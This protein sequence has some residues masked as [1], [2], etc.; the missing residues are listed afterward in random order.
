MSRQLALTL[1][2]ALTSTA[3][4]AAASEVLGEPLTAD[5]E[6][7]PIGDIVADPDAWAGRRVRVEGEVTGVCLKM[8]CWL[9]LVSPEG[10]ALR[11]KVEDGVIV[12]PPTAVGQRAA[13]EGEVEILELGREEYVGWLEHQAE[14]TGEPFDPATVGDGPH[15]IVRLRGLGA[16]IAGP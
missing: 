11:V 2:L 1:L 16:E 12:F 9:E 13:A 3:A 15:R 8:G 4:A 6:V 10:E 14:E 7:T 5:L